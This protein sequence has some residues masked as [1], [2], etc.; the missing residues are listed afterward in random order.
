MNAILACTPT[1]KER[2]NL[3]A[4]FQISGWERCLGGSL[5]LCKEKFYGS[6]HD[7]LRTWVAAAVDDGWD[8]KDVRYGPPPDARASPKKNGGQKKPVEAAPKIEMPKLDF[9]LDKPSTPSK[10]KD[11]WL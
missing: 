3:R 11:A 1:T 6:V 7:G 2:N 9:G 4:Q 8:V 10:V 5:R